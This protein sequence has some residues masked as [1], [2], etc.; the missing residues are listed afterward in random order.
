[1][2]KRMLAILLALVL[3]MGMI[4][5]MAIPAFAEG[6]TFMY[7][8]W[9]GSEV[10]A[11]KAQ[12]SE[13]G[14]TV[15]E[16]TG[17]TTTLGSS[18]YY[19][20]NNITIN[21]NLTVTGTANDPT[22]LILMDGACLTVNGSISPSSTNNVLEIYGGEQDNG[23]LI[24]SPGQEA[25]GIS[26]IGGSTSFQKLTINGGT[27]EAT[28]GKTGA[29]ICNGYR[30]SFL[31]EVIING[32]T[33]I[34]NGN[35]GAGIGGTIINNQGHA[36]GPIMIHGGTVKATGTGGGAGIGG[37]SGAGCGN[38]T[39]TG[40]TV[41]A[42]AKY[43]GAGI[44]SGYGGSSN[45]QLS[46]TNSFIMAGDQAPGSHVNP[47]QYSQ[48]RNSYVHI[49]PISSK[50]Q[51]KH[52]FHWIDNYNS[53][54]NTYELKEA[55]KICG[56]TH[57]SYNRNFAGYTA[58]ESIDAP[59]GTYIDT[60]YLPNDRTRVV[61]D[62]FVNSSSEYWF[63]VSVYDGE[64]G[65]WLGNYDDH[66]LSAAYMYYKTTMNR[67][68]PPISKRR[69][70]VE[71]NRNYI[72]VDGKKF[73]KEFPNCTPTDIKG[74][75]SLFAKHIYESDAGSEEGTVGFAE[76]QL[77][78]CYGC[79]IYEDDALKYYYVPCTSDSEKGLYDLLEGKFYPLLSTSG[80]NASVL[81]EGNLWIV[82]AIAVLALCA[83]AVLLIVKKK[84]RPAC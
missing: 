63:G 82:A 51:Y 37:S 8:E 26:A 56:Y 75:L 35:G 7:R 15:T 40:G 71:L 55:C 77:V 4:P 38:V 23:K 32:G 72:F 34:A 60:G 45:G 50:N 42:E 16:F 6:E 59:A 53:K 68:H 74:T 78:T 11:F 33:V 24:V 54:T 69:C 13:L 29:G 14:E 3:T 70:R 20:K 80:G 36:S 49:E 39:I 84:N 41:E 10:D 64:Y 48:S 65:F 66:N 21:D 28:G 73:G 81:S 18:W 9:Y 76:N 79:E 27:V 62:V 2:K 47:T 12:L 46:V 22:R 19:V 61:M 25:I 57:K 44:G 43:G 31:N 58:V 30:D 52:S 83:I 67:Q 5:C 1:M 17:E